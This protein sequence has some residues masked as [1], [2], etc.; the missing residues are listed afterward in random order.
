[1][2]V[3]SASRYSLLV[4]L[5]TE[6]SG[7]KRR[8][9][10]LQLTDIFMSAP[11]RRTEMEGSLFDGIYAAVAADLKIAVRAEIAHKIATSNAPLGQT[12]RRMA[13]DEIEV[14]V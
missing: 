6:R 7:E 4:E 3:S 1:M 8:E 2:A 14:V 5:A 12:A 10:L 11:T 13:M 9:L